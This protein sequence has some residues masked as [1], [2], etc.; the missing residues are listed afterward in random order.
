MTVN[1]IPRQIVSDVT[2]G[3]VIH[4]PMLYPAHPVTLTYLDW[5][6]LQS[7]DVSHTSCALGGD[8]CVWKES[9]N[10]AFQK[11]EILWLGQQEQLNQKV[12]YELSLFRLYLCFLPGTDTGQ[13]PSLWVCLKLKASECGSPLVRY[14][15]HNGCNER[16]FGNRRCFFLK[17]QR[18][19]RNK[20]WMGLV[21]AVKKYKNWG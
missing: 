21:F 16:I 20:R 9:T 1:P 17:T 12:L 3:G 15:D 13:Y 19:E 14:G 4:L 5:F 11:K 18:E 2:E 7:A 6:N 8:M 10:V